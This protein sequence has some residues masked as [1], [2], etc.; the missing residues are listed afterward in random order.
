[1]SKSYNELIKIDSFEDRYEY[2]KIGGKVGSDTFGYERYLNQ[3]LYNSPEW[4]SFRDKIII[5]DNGCD[6]GIDDRKI[7]KGVMI[8]V[9]HINPI[10]I[11]D[12]RERNFSIFDPN[13]VICTTF[14]T[15]NAI[16]F[17]S[18]DLLYHDPVERKPNDTCPWR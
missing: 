16:H 3:V 15:H 13:N 9:H 14:Q 10:T 5:R 17:G 7:P 6:L 11:D 8:L 4:K 2:L 1:M 18:S 12:I